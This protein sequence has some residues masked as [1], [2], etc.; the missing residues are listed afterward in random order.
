MNVIIITINVLLNDENI[1][2]VITSEWGGQMRTFYNKNI[3]YLKVS[4]ITNI[5]NRIANDMDYLQIWSDYDYLTR[6]RYVFV[7]LKLC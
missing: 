7:L 4:V 1:H 6:L 5:I 3:R 2:L